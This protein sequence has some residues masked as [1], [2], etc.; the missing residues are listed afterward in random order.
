MGGRVTSVVVGQNLNQSSTAE[1]VIHSVSPSFSRHHWIPGSPSDHGQ[2]ATYVQTL[3]GLSFDAAMSQDV[4]SEE[5]ADEEA[6]EDDMYDSDD[7]FDPIF[8]DFYDFTSEQWITSPQVQVGE[9]VEGEGRTSRPMA[10]QP[11]DLLLFLRRWFNANRFQYFLASLCDQNANIGGEYMLRARSPFVNE[12]ILGDVPGGIFRDFL[13]DF[14]RI[15]V[16]CTLRELFCLA[17]NL[18]LDDLTVDDDAS[19]KSIV[20]SESCAGFPDTRWPHPAVR[21]S[22]EHTEDTFARTSAHTYI[23]RVAFES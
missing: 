7:D 2:S 6:D 4:E 8:R 14:F 1:L 22:I 10:C 23:P 3:Y 18:L 15:S 16:D 19:G 11:S 20:R 13:D 17:I 9:P 5:E 12:E 21:Q